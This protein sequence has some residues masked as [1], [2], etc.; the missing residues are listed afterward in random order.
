MPLQTHL[1]K[2]PPHQFSVPVIVPWWK[3]LLLVALLIASSVVIFK[4]NI[5]FGAALLLTA[6]LFHGLGGFGVPELIRMESRIR[7][8]NFLVSWGIV[9]ALSISLQYGIPQFL[10]LFSTFGGDMPLLTQLTMR[11]YPLLLLLPFFVGLIWMIWPIQ[12][13]RLRVAAMFAWLYVGLILMAIG[14]LYLPI[15]KM[16]SVV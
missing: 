6:V 10:P 12:H 13:A 16:G 1:Q 2:E 11:A 3:I 5:W 9:T 4:T 14:T 8:A 7:I 15:L